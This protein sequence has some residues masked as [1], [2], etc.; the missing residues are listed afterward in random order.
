MQEWN[1]TADNVLL[2]HPLGIEEEEE[3]S[4]PERECVLQLE[5]CPRLHYYSV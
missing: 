5:V 3:E 1:A 2:T 4:G